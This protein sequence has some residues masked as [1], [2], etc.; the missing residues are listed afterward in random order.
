MFI[1][2]DARSAGGGPRARR[3]YTVGHSPYEVVDFI[4]AVNGHSRFFGERITST[5]RR[6]R[7][8]TA[9]LER[10]KNVTTEST[11]V[12]SAATRNENNGGC[13]VSVLLWSV[14]GGWGTLNE[15]PSYRC[16]PTR[17][18]RVAQCGQRKR[19]AARPPL[20]RG[21]PLT[22]TVSRVKRV[23]PL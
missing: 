15:H 12:A 9:K 11:Q 10:K 22:P 4:F 3:L 14:W 21:P 5:A 23:G 19:P 20:D 7:R 6:G 17:R 18:Y 1:R 16:R 8:L 13:G 2:F